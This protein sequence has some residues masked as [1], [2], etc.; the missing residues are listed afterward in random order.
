[1]LSNRGHVGLGDEPWWK[2]TGLELR[3][4]C[5]ESEDRAYGREGGF[6]TLW[7]TLNLPYK[8]I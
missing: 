2:E 4:C 8:S 7:Q 1:M 3:Q 5:H 6:S